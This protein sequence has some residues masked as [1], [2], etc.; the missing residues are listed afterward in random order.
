MFLNIE[1]NLPELH[2]LWKHHLGEIYVVDGYCYNVIIKDYEVL[3]HSWREPS[4]VLLA[5]PLKLWNYIIDQEN[6][7]SFFTKIHL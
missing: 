6:Q 5:I 7:I 1:K 3:Y 4:N 2:S